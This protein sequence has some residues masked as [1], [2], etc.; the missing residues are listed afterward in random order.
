MHETVYHC[1]S[2]D[3]SGPCPFALSGTSG[4]AFEGSPLL[5]TVPKPAR[6]EYPP[7][8]CGQIMNALKELKTT[9]A[10]TVVVNYPKIQFYWFPILD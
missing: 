1:T 4:R 2:N 8:R 9:L 6:Q 5:V 7:A 3:C 10:V